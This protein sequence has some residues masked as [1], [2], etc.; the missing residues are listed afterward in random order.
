MVLALKK[1]IFLCLSLAIQTLEQCN[2]L[3]K[4]YH[5]TQNSL[6]LRI[7][8]N[9]L[10]E[11][12]CLSEGLSLRL[13]KSSWV[14]IKLF[15]LSVEMKRKTTYQHLDIASLWQ[16]RLVLLEW[17]L[18]MAGQKFMNSQCGRYRAEIPDGEQFCSTRQGDSWCV[19]VCA[20]G[21]INVSSFLAIRVETQIMELTWEKTQERTKSSSKVRMSGERA[22]KECNIL[23]S[24]TTHLSVY[25]KLHFVTK[26]HIMR[27]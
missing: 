11:L 18:G 10:I 9:C 16:I 13:T 23:N 8:V 6:C 21:F 27:L 25:G 15:K 14:W 24:V 2:S 3:W 5:N 22:R 7:A 19:C 1:R 20:W 26:N 17:W 12:Y 4:E